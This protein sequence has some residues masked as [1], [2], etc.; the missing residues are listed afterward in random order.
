MASPLLLQ[1]PPSTLSSTQTFF[2]IRNTH[3]VPSPIPSSK[4]SSY[5]YYYKTNLTLK[6]ITV[7]FALTESEG[8]PK[9]LNEPDP[10]SKIQIL[11]QQLAVIINF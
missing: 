6:S 3:L 2:F 5:Y 8:F 7:P 11:L 10:D 1:R 9:S 4:P